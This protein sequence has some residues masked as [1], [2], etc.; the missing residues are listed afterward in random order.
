MSTNDAERSGRPKN[1][2]TPEI[3][4]KIHD[5]VLDDPK[6]KVR[7]L[8]EAVSISIGAVTKILHE[9]LRMRNLTAKSMPRLLTIDQ[10]RQRVEGEFA[11]RPLTVR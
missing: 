6:V 3:I 8:P 9:Y 5:I 10:K 7:E 4:E 1:V 2:T 11:D